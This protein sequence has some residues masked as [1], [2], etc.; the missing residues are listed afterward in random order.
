ML[1]IFEAVEVGCDGGQDTELL[2]RNNWVTAMPMEANERDVRSQARN[3]RSVSVSHRIP[4]LCVRSGNTQSEVISCNTALIVQFQS[5]VFLRYTPKP[6]LMGSCIFIIGLS[7][8]LSLVIIVVIVIP[9]GIDILICPCKIPIG[10]VVAFS[11]IY[12]LRCWMLG[13]S[14]LS[15]F[16]LV[17][18]IVPRISNSGPVVSG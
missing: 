13:L 2:R 14:V 9:V 18:F 6:R 1:S 4:D 17:I 10:A 11:I 7:L 12:R 5:T 3:V 8:G 16:I 15:R